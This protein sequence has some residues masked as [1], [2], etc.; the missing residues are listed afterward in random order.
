MKRTLKGLG[1]LL[2]LVAGGYFVVY[3]HRAL[4]GK[5]LSALLD[6]RVLAA[7]ACLTLLYTLSILT[8]ALAWTRL[9]HAMRQPA[10][11]SRLLSIVAT[12]Q[13]GKYL[14]GNVAQHIGRIALTRG[15]GVQ[16]SPALLSIAYELL[17]ALVVSAHIGALTLLWAPPSALLQWQ[18]TQYRVPLL[19]GVTV[20]ALVALL[21]AP[22]VAIWLTRLRNPAREELLAAPARLHLDPV[23]VGICYALYATSF[24]MIGYGLWLVAGSL[25]PAGVSIP[26]PIFLIGAFASSWILGFVAPGA[27]AGLGI[28]EAMLSAWLSGVLPPVEVVLLVVALRIATTLGDL[29]NFIWGSVVMFRRRDG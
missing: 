26:G 22:R 2:A 8:T 18:I 27:P 1:I 29:I 14:P 5:D 3:A 7:M 25:A 17:L 21:L 9:L 6:S 4:A 20:G 19:I 16:M 13:F 10:K 11:F 24:V 23:T 28:R 15:I 12:T